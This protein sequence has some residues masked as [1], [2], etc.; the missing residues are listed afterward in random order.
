MSSPPVT[1]Y[2]TILAEVEDRLT[3]PTDF[4]VGDYGTRRGHLTP[5]P[6]DKAPGA[7]IV[8]GDDDPKKG[9]FCGGR[10]G[11]FTVSIFTRDDLGSSAADPYLIE[12]YSRMAEPFAAG[13]I[14][15]PA[16]IR[17]E[18]EIADGDAARTDCRFEVE[19]PTAGEWSLELP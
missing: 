3:T 6:R 9:N 5:M 4:V 2:E 12:L 15:R 17:R 7:H 13:I 8:G 14:V 10:I 16:G 19:Y 18:T 1:G 11:E